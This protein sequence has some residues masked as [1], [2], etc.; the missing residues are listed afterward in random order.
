MAKKSFK[1]GIDEILGFS[2][3]KNTKTTRKET[4][5]ESRTN[6][7]ITSSYLEKLKSVAYWERKSL[8]AIINEALSLYIKNYEEAHGEIKSHL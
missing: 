7:V 5:I 8:K 2:E 6:V 3:V 4:E 1:G